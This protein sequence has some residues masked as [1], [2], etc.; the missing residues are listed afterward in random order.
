MIYFDQ[1][2]KPGQ[3]HIVVDQHIVTG[4]IDNSYIKIPVSSYYEIDYALDDCPQ[5]EIMNLDGLPC[6]PFVLKK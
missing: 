3:V 1:L 2:L 4:I 5:V 6:S